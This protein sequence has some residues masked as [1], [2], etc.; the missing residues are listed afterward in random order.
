MNSYLL[1]SFMYQIKCVK[2][3]ILVL[4]TTRPVDAEKK[5][6]S[7]ISVTWNRETEFDFFQ[8]AVYIFHCF[9][10]QK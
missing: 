3:D 1:F 4:L 2:C 6:D 10:F 9:L 5:N 8:Y 7:T